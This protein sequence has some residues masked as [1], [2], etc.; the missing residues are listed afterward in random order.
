M[1]TW[2]DWKEFIKKKHMNTKLG[3]IYMI[4]PNPVR[5]MAI[6]VGMSHNLEY[7]MAQYANFYPQG[8]TIHAISQQKIPDLNYNKGN[9][10]PD[11]AAIAERKLLEKLK[12]HVMYRKEWIYPQSKQVIMKAIRDI[13]LLH[14]GENQL[15]N[16]IF[17]GARIKA[18]LGQ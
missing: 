17:S 18:L 8:F 11:F 16:K 2:N 6:K 7:R 4:Q 14:N 5:E 12:A 9:R 10:S 3:G 13:H 1:A 15:K